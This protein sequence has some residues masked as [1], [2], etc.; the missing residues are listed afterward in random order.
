MSLCAHAVLLMPFL[1]RAGEIIVSEFAADREEEAV[2]LRPRRL[3]LCVA[4]QSA[5]KGMAEGA[6]RNWLPLPAVFLFAGEEKKRDSGV[7]NGTAGLQLRG[8][9]PLRKLISGHTDWF[10]GSCVLRHF[11]IRRPAPEPCVRAD[12]IADIRASAVS[13]TQLFLPSTTCL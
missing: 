1:R 9:L 4:I 3:L 8:S 10:S 11:L 13:S 2:I 5:C 7:V 12:T 6:A